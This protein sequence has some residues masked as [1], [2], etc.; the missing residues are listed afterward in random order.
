M[1]LYNTVWHKRG[2]ELPVNW[3][4]DQGHHHRDVGS[5]LKL[6]V[7]GDKERDLGRVLALVLVLTLLVTAIVYRFCRRQKLSETSSDTTERTGTEA[8]AVTQQLLR[9]PSDAVLTSESGRS[10]T[11][12]HSHA[13]LAPLGQGSLSSVTHYF[14]QE[15]HRS[16]RGQQ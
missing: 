6:V 3:V 12:L 4:P 10:S 7:L 13:H 1:Y 5:V 16:F 9:G 8:S 15:K 11:P 14:S 2:N